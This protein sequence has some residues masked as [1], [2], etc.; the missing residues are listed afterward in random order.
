MVLPCESG[1]GHLST[2]R[3]PHLEW[4]PLHRRR[5]GEWAL[6]C[7]FGHSFPSS[8][9][10]WRNHAT[11]KHKLNGL[12]VVKLVKI[13]DVA[14]E[15]GVSIAAVSFAINGT[16]SLSE[17]TRK[18]ILDTVERM[19]YRPNVTARRLVS[20]KVNVIGLV[21]PQPGTEFFLFADMAILSGIGVVASRMGHNV[22]LS[23]YEGT[24]KSSVLDLVQEGTV[25][26]LTFLLPLDDTST[27]RELNDMN[28]PYVLMSRP[29]EGLSCN[30]VDV[31][32]MDAAYQAVLALIKGGHERIGF[33]SPGPMDYLVSRDRHA[34]Y[35]AAMLNHGLE[36][37]S[38]YVF[39]GVGSLDSG[40]AAM[41]QFL[42]LDEPPTAILA[43]ANMLA[44][45]VMERMEQAGLRCPEDVAII[46]FDNSPLAENYKLTAIEIPRGD[47]AR[48]ATALLMKKINQS[49]RTEPESII[50]PFEIIYRNTFLRPGD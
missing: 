46:T 10:Y 34:G 24:G 32:N 30:W 27:Y 18:K 17:E 47:I 5:A 19:N 37:H 48:E 15:A 41:E 33:V 13:R 14:K 11:F 38:G 43:G 28:F 45:G 7:N 29:P 44:L 20:G 25:R 23:W 4:C 3:I 35:R 21:M 49:T 50:I 1:Y 42:S 39:E 16:G 22:L 6:R 8:L 12:G 31:D 26:G 40:I 9:K 36:Y 2:S